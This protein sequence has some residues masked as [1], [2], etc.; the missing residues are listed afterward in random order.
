VAH[1]DR[2][3]WYTIVRIIQD[4]INLENIK[5]NIE[6][7]GTYL[8]ENADTQNGFGLASTLKR[9]QYLFGSHASLHIS[10]TIKNTVLTSLQIPK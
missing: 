4:E 7:T 10:N 8:T 1:F 9:L 3:G 2:N 6:N 5:I